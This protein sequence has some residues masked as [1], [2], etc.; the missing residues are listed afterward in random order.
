MT[1]I[2]N[3]INS[4]LVRFF[5]AWLAL[6]CCVLL[7]IPSLGWATTC[8]DSIPE[9]LIRETDLIF[10][11]KVID[12]KKL[13]LNKFDIT[14]AFEK[15]WARNDI[16]R[17]NKYQA[18]A[19]IMKPY[20]DAKNSQKL[21]EQPEFFVRELIYPRT[22]FKVLVPYKGSIV[23]EIEVE[24]ISGEIGEEEMVFAYGNLREGYRSGRCM[25]FSY[26]YS[27]DKTYRQRYQ[28]ALD[29]YRNHWERLATAL[30]RSSHNADLLKEQGALFLQYHDFDAAQWSYAELRWHHPKDLAGIVGLADVR[31][32]R[33]HD[34]DDNNKKSLYEQAVTVYRN[35]LELAPD[36]H[37]AR[38]GETLALLYLERWPEIGK[39][40]RD[41]SDYEYFKFG[42]DGA[43]NF[44]VGRNLVGANFRNV[45]LYGVNFS[46]TN[47]RHADFSG[48]SISRS[49]FTGATLTRAAFRDVKFYDTKFTGAKLQHADFTKANL[50]HTDF[51]NVNLQGANFTQARIFQTNFSHAD[52]RGADL[53]KTELYGDNLWDNA[54]LNNTKF[55]DA[56]NCNISKTTWAIGFDPVAAGM[57]ACK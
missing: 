45:N 41:F 48:A 6:S 11:G 38:H 34:E 18:L 51:S 27:G 49:N 26:F 1:T 30:R 19:K 56:K 32:N 33:A 47:I 17:W 21:A 3:F 52:L 35:V 9:E 54:K 16:D 36:H 37:A 13:F 31:L 50:E 22:T 14:D 28:A 29:S 40:V 5:R 39:N 15:I 55:N 20:V 42:E 24:G 8:A 43:M 10:K 23:D 12:T 4:F 57:K 44:F 7:F 25:G 53:S 46:R 2:Q